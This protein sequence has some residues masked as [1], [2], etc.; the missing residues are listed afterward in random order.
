MPPRRLRIVVAGELSSRF[1][2]AFPGMALQCD[3]GR[4][5][6]TGTV[7]D[8]AHLHGLLNQVS[9]LGLDLV[10]VVPVEDDVP[11]QEQEHGGSVAGVRTG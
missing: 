1:A 4:T 7:V 8:Q 2:S 10:S 9:A 5:V 6:I 3:A 11:G